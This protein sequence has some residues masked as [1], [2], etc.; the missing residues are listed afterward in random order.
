M[1][2]PIILFSDHPAARSGLARITRDLALQIHAYLGDTFR[3]ATLGYGHPGSTRLPF[4]QYHWNERGDFIPTELPMIWREFCGGDQGVLMT[5][6]DVQRFLGLA[7]PTFCAEKGFGDWITPLRKS[8]RLRLWGY[9]P[10]D[11]HSVDGGLGPQLGHTLSHY[12]RRLV[13]SKWAREIVRK[14]LP[15]HEC[16]VIPHGIDDATFFPR[17]KKVARES[18]DFITFPVRQWPQKGTIKS[19]KDALWVG[20]VATN[21][22]RKDWGLG[23][24]TIKELRK[25]RAVR[26]W[27]HTDAVKREWSLLELLSAFGLLDC[28]TVTTGNVDDESMAWLYSSMDLTLGIGRGEGFGYPIFESIACGTPCVTHSYG[29]QSDFMHYFAPCGPLRIEGP[30]SL[31]RP[32][33]DGQRWANYI[34]NDSVLLAVLPDE[35]R[36]K[37]LWPTFAE[38]FMKGAR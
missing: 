6:G 38:W 14:T 20:I 15:N 25:T 8:G 19:E 1:T 9:F 34:Q 24:E 18:F 26:L 22:A 29:A 16:D 12:D 33:C 7:D 35:L 21:Q 13:P 3:V 23:L 4:P 11:S 30:L 2:T 10:I 36:W 28:A 17:D 37:N 5:I 31:L 32:T 27:I